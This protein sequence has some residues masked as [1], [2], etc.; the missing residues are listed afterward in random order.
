MIEKWE[1]IAGYEGL[2]QVSNFGGVKCCERTMT[3]SNGTNRKIKEK[4]LKQLTVPNAGNV[5][6]K[7]VLLYNESGQKKVLCS[8][9]GG[10]CIY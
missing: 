2:Y 4:V 6:Y 7:S 8:Q 9:V 10:K 5:T 1:D 3:L